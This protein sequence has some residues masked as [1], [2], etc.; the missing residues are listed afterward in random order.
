ML[1]H[2][3]K[4]DALFLDFDGTLVEFANSPARVSVDAHLLGLLERLEEEA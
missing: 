2:L 1:P 3:E 4:T